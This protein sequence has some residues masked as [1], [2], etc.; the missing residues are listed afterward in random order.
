MQPELKNI[1]INQIYA[2]SNYRKT[3]NDKSL[4][5][6]A[7]SIKENG[8]LEPIIVRPNGKGFVIV[9]GER[10]YRASKLARLATIPAVV[11]DV[12]DAEVLKLQL[13]ENVQREGVQYMEEA[14]GL[15]KLRDELSLDVSEIAKIVGKS[16]AWVYQVLKLTQMSGEAQR[17][18]ANGFLQKPVAQLIS[19]LHSDEDQTKAANALARTHSGKLVDI[20]FAR[21]YIETQIEADG[22]PRMRRLRNAVQ[23]ENGN[24]YCA[25][26]KKYLVNFST[27]QFEYWKTIVRGRTDVTTL[28]EAVEHV[29]MENNSKSGGGGGMRPIRKAK[30]RRFGHFLTYAATL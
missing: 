30:D 18:A 4:S 27:I 24:D 19:R 15:Q 10:R 1:P 25:N 17:L 29:M 16:E 2:A 13:I 21:Q 7:Q 3:F 12:T 8:V 11:R 5:E 23:K 20:R 28:S 6:L 9:A 26:W 14:Y 22:R